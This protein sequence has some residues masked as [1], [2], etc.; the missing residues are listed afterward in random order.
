MGRAGWSH[1]AGM[2][3]DVPETL[4]SPGVPRAFDLGSS[5]VWPP[6]RDQKEPCV[7]RFPP[8]SVNNLVQ[9]C[10]L[11]CTREGMKSICTV[12]KEFNGLENDCRSEHPALDLRKNWMLV[13]T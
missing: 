10:P 3:W 6:K 7:L 12:T 11:Y 4:Q 9:Q 2:N 8:V 1:P 13:L 5:P